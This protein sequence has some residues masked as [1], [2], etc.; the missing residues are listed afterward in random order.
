MAASAFPEEQ[1]EGAGV[2]SVPSLPCS[3]QHCT[4]DGEH[5]APPPPL[6]GEPGNKNFP[7]PIA[8][9]R[10]KANRYRNGFLGTERTACEAV[11][12]LGGGDTAR[13]QRRQ[14]GLCVPRAKRSCHLA[15][16][17]HPPPG[18][19]MQQ[20]LILILLLTGLALFCCR[21]QDTGLPDTT[22]RGPRDTPEVHQRKQVCHWPCK[23]PQQKPSCPPGV[24]LVRDGCGCCKICA[25]QPGD[26]CNEADLCDPHKG[27]YC[28]YSADRPR[29]ETGV[30]AYLVAVGCEINRVHYQNGQVFQ[31]NPLF[32]CLCVSGAI[33]CMPLF[34]PKLA[35]SRCSGAKIGKTSN[36][37]LGSSQRQ[38]P[39][40]HKTMPA[41]RNL[42][43]IWKRKC[44]V[45]ATKWTPCS[46]TCGMGISNRVTNENSNCEMRNEKRLCYIQPCSSNVSKTVEIPK[47][48]ACQPTFQLAK[49]EKFVFS[50]CSS[51]QSYKPTF[52]GMC[53]D[54]RCCIPNKST[55]ITIQFDCPNEGSMKWKMLWIISCVC[56]RNCREPG[57]MFSEL[58]IL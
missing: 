46:R 54:R 3:E 52:C 34:I 2:S 38:L 57:D 44:L 7:S 49:A 26:L 16:P 41:Y 4:Q 29:F 48:K 47:G 14:G 9:N 58:K 43:L 31:P 18:G 22:P 24:S 45:Q 53:L 20:L 32:S 23:C 28:D 42:P 5:T 30:C 1:M 40:S 13:V 10:T 35:G 8:R 37:V 55:M 6:M 27:L 39:E 21:A 25:K 36:C 15:S 56:Q 12:Q 50:G 11:A 19:G 51:T 17:P 33:G